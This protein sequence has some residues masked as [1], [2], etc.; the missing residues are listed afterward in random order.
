MT[1][2]PHSS[3]HLK[4]NLIFLLLLIHCTDKGDFITIQ[5]NESTPSA[6]GGHVQRHLV[7]IAVTGKIMLPTPISTKT[8]LHVDL[9]QDPGSNSILSIE[10]QPTLL[11]SHSC[12]LQ[13]K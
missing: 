3:S 5:L 4:C 1:S 9:L 2:Q 7:I 12:L 10:R 11:V 6:E 8:L 13:D